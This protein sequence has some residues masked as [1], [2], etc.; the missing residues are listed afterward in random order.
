MNNKLYLVDRLFKE[1]N[2]DVATLMILIA[3]NFPL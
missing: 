2:A 1:F 3:L